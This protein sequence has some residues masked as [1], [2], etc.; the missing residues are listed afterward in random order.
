MALRQQ[1]RFCRAPDGARIAV[2]TMGTGTPL[3]RA[4]HWLSHVEFDARSP[5]WIHWLRELSSGRTYIRY[6]QRGCGDIQDEARHPVLP[7]RR[8]DGGA[9]TGLPRGGRD[10]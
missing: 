9:H 2:A 6:D 10:Q 4:T 3:V 1:I 8:G 5:V 7:E